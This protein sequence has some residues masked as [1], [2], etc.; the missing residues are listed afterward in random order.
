[1]RIVVRK[2][3][4]N[5]IMQPSRIVPC[6]AVKNLSASAANLIS[7]DRIPPGKFNIDLILYARHGRLLGGS[8]LDRAVHGELAHQLMQTLQLVWLYSPLNFPPVG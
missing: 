1:M 4:V 3:V 6:T 2:Q 5:E 8:V 7:P